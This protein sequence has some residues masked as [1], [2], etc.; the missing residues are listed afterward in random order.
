M[1]I[2]TDLGEDITPI[3]NLTSFAS[4]DC[5]LANLSP[6]PACPILA[7]FDR[8]PQLLQPVADQV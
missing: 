4:F 8:H 5:V 2:G 3:D 6:S 1:E 7:I